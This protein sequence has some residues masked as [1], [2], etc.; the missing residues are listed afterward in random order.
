MSKL[1]THSNF[2]MLYYSYIGL[3]AF[4]TRF[5]KIMKSV[6]V[7]NDLNVNLL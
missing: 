7:D 1:H 5:N 6:K 3:H 2:L 4:V